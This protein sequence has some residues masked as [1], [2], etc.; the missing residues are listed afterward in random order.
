M[1]PILELLVSLLI[2]LG[3]IF[4]LVGS[5]GLLKLPDLMSR[6]H[7]PTKATT[8]GLGGVLLASMLFFLASS[9][10]LS[11]H[12]LLISMFLFITAPI[13]AHFIAKA[14]LHKQQQLRGQLPT[15][16]SGSGWSTYDPP[17]AENSHPPAAENA[18]PPEAEGCDPPAA[19]GTHPPQQ[20]G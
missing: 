13:T 12:E 11:I 10:E 14:H 3:S 8:L 4:V 9:G 17:M 5:V 20:H 18:H 6:L 2:V 7:A 15:T 1:H 19:E 16:A